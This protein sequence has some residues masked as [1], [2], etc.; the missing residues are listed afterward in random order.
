ETDQLIAR[1]E[2]RLA[3][4]IAQRRLKLSA[5]LFN[6]VGKKRI[7]LAPIRRG[8]AGQRQRRHS[9]LAFRIERQGGGGDRQPRKQRQPARAADTLFHGIEKLSRLCSADKAL[10]QIRRAVGALAR[11]ERN[12]REAVRAVFGRR[13][14]RRL[15]RGQRVDLPNDQEQHEGDDQKIDHRIDEKAVIERGGACRLRRRDRR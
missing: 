1:V 6:D 3:Q 12:R 7:P 8:A 13:R 9:Q 14:R 2:K 5:E 15:R 4:A 11:L 10:L